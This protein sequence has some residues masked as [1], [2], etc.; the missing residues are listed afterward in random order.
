MVPPP[1]GIVPA[2]GLAAS[3]AQHN[4]NVVY[5]KV[6]TVESFFLSK[7]TYN[8][9]QLGDGKVLD[10]MVSIDFSPII[11]YSMF[12]VIVL[13]FILFTVALIWPKK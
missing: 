9:V 11:N 8:I 12:G 6:K 3:A 7:T 2:I 5:V 1:V 13:L 4:P 10:S